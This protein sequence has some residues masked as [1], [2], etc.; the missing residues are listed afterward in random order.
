MRLFLTWVVGFVLGGMGVVELKGQG[1][2]SRETAALWGV[3]HH[4]G[5]WIAVGEQGV[6]TRS[7]DA[8]NWTSGTLGPATSTWLL[9]VAWGEPGWVVVG[10]G[11]TILFSADGMTWES[12]ATGGVR[13]NG[14]AWGGGRFLAVGEAG[15]VRT[16]TDGRNWSAPQQVMPEGFLRGVAYGNGV[17]LVAGQRG[18]LFRTAD[19]VAFEE[20]VVTDLNIEALTWDGRFFHATGEAGLL[21][22][23]RR[24]DSW[25]LAQ[26][27]S[28]APFGGY[29]RGVAAEQNSLVAV[30]AN[31]LWHNSDATG[32]Q[33]VMPRT[34]TSVNLNAVAGGSGKLVAVGD[35]RT[36]IARDVIAT[37]SPEVGLQPL[38]SALYRG[39]SVTLAASAV[40]GS[41]PLTFQWLKDG[42]VIPGANTDQLALH[43]LQ[44]ADAGS[45][46]L[47]VQNALGADEAY[48]IK[49][50]VDYAPPSRPTPGFAVDIRSAITRRQNPVDELATSRRDFEVRMVAGV[51]IPG[52]A[53]TRRAFLVG[54]FVAPAGTDQGRPAGRPR[55][56]LAAL[57]ASGV[58]ASFDLKLDLVVGSRPQVFGGEGSDLLVAVEYYPSIS[59]PWVVRLLRTDQ[60]GTID[61]G[62]NAELPI[63]SSSAVL[64][65]LPLS[66]GGYLVLYQ[67]EGTYGQITGL[68]KLRGDGSFDPSF[69]ADASLPAQLDDVALL[70][71]GAI[72]WTGHQG[73]NTHFGRLR[74]DGTADPS[75]TPVTRARASMDP[76][77]PSH[78]ITAAGRWVRRAGGWYLAIGPLPVSFSS[79]GNTLLLGFDEEGTWRE[80]AGVAAIPGGVKFSEGRSYV[81][82]DSSGTSLSR[83][84]SWRLGLL[85]VD[86]DGWSD[87]ELRSGSAFISTLFAER[88]SAVLG[89]DDRTLLLVGREARWINADG[90]V[91]NNSGFRLDTLRANRLT[92]A[93]D[94]TIYVSGSFDR[95]NG[96]DSPGLI[97]FPAT[98]LSSERRLQN[99]S[100]RAR[101]GAGEERLIMGA[102]AEGSPPLDL[103]VRAAGPALADY[104][105]EGWLPNPRLS[106]IRGATEV[107]TNDDWSESLSSWFTRAGAA[108]WPVG[109]KDAAILV[110]GVVG[111]FTSV[112][113]DAAG[114]SGVALGEVYRTDLPAEEAAYRLINVSARSS[115]ATGEGVLI[116]GFVLS[117]SDNQ[118]MLIR[119]VGPALVAYGVNQ[120][121]SRPVLRLYRDDELIME[122]RRWDEDARIV[123]AAASAGAFPL[124]T[125]SADAAL[126]IDLPPG[127]YTAVISSAD[128]AEGIALVEVYVVN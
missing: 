39:D 106:V 60:D 21:A 5:T 64:K 16:S 41:G 14:V 104:G 83:Y 71:S 52:Q 116:A 96:V 122:N 1:G 107:G 85:E 94:T 75:F 66:A 37:I 17:F 103:L 113:E 49:L 110:P 81:A 44:P 59:A 108:P 4:D 77:P 50:K 61:A 72:L 120:A 47:R 69:A 23:S 9:A 65:V 89:D 43:D 125:G 121:L 105:V 12:V 123:T 27:G 98:R 15:T 126:L 57:S 54:S 78:Q 80:A 28:P 42:R 74:S 2:G 109:S 127:N 86:E 45:Y 11:G 24:G 67:R 40:R 100:V 46:S 115:V 70:D 95:A 87:I 119:G 22:R 91:L 118:R 97:A 68:K 111:A 124:A 33:F 18:R 3:A 73:V 7:G 101:A 25:D 84:Q 36:R 53:E 112:V 29:F 58:L 79:V 8:L 20:L 10:D 114:G 99:F 34:L 6:I 26:F 32:A 93:G 82:F 38:N 88:A 92:I 128:D 19:G 62:F 76:V 51:P 56:G 55:Y 90:T 30:G 31:G 117:G 63:D 13:L 48:P 102:V 35:L